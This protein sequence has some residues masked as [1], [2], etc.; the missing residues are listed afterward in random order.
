MS[1]NWISQYVTISYITEEEG[2][3]LKDLKSNKFSRLIEST[4]DCVSCFQKI[5]TKVHDNTHIKETLGT[6]VLCLRCKKFKN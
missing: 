3:A 1:E 5:L 2:K 6:L 4:D